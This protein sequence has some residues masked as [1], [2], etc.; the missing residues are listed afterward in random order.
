MTDDVFWELIEHIEITRSDESRML[1]PL[2][3]AL[4]KRSPEDLMA[5]ET[6]LSAKLFHLDTPTHYDCT[7]EPSGDSFLYFRL[8]VV[9]S[10]EVFYYD[11]LERPH[12]VDE[13]LPWL[14]GLLYVARNEYQKQTGSELYCPA[15][16]DHESFSNPAWHTAR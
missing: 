2:R 6:I 4:K 1:A 7:A 3:L 12:R 5:F 10:G 9:G 14:E 16:F 13:P 11:F 15:A 8:F